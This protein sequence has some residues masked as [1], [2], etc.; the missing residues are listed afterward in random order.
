MR[1]GEPTHT[2]PPAV[3]ACICCGQMV[4]SH[5]AWSLPGYRGFRCPPCHDLLMREV[6]R[7][8][9]KRA[10]VEAPPYPTAV[11]PVAPV[12]DPEAER[13]ARTRKWA[14]DLRLA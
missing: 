9:G 11:E 1:Q 12:P 7:G 4:P 10:K 13:R 8:R 2:S 6:S 5:L 3:L 14:R